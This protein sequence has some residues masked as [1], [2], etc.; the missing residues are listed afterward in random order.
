MTNLERVVAVLERHREARQWTDEAV[1]RDLLTE[2]GMDA[3]TH[4][5]TEDE[6]TAAEAHAADVAA[7]AEA[8]RAALTAQAVSST[9]SA[10]PDDKKAALPAALAP[11]P[12]YLNGP[13]VHDVETRHYSDGTSATGTP[14]LPD[15]S[16]EQQAARDAEAAFRA[17]AEREAEMHRE[18][19]PAA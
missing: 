8:A 5:V 13:A 18:I 4:V 7:K 9:L 14:P 11:L 3:D 16:P 15:L 1:A 19:P 12:D 17:E 10:L 6:V 2:L